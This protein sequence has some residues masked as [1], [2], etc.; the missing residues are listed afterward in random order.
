[1]IKMVL[2][3]NVIYNKKKIYGWKKTCKEIVSLSLYKH[4]Y[5]F[6]KKSM[7]FITFTAVSV[8]SVFDIFTTF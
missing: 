6:K 2:K 7:T 3:K 5:L 8:S 4:M 1:M